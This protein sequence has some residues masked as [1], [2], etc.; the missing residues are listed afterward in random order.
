MIS[1]RKS[2]LWIHD[3]MTHTSQ[4]LEPVW[5]AAEE[6]NPRKFRRNSKSDDG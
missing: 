4:Q 5:G 1:Y 2:E 6:S 3:G